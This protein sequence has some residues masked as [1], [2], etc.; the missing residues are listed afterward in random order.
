MS[1]APDGMR[2]SA[3]AGA[4]G[5][6]ASGSGR[7]PV[8]DTASLLG[9]S[10]IFR[11]S[12]RL[13]QPVFFDGVT[14]NERPADI[15]QLGPLAAAALVGE[16]TARVKAAAGGW[17]DRI[18]YFTTHRFALS[19]GNLNA[20]DRVKQQLSVRVARRGEEPFGGGDLDKPRQILDTDAVRHLVDDRVVVREVQVGQSE[21]ALQI[22]H[23]I[24]DLR[25]D[26]DVERGSR[27]I[28][29]KEF[30]VRGECASNRNPLPL[31]A[32]E[33]VREFIAVHR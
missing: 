29:N 20:R 19:A 30:R 7:L 10:L 11:V 21:L 26:R 27:F 14:G 23:Q 25:L 1:S 5:K 15:D 28:A 31:T 18:G 13:R 17:I 6:R 9:L 16:G 22:L 12:S 4:V 3:A 24:E 8:G 32:G 2:R 33:F